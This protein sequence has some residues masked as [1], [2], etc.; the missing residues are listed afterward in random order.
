MMRYNKQPVQDKCLDEVEQ[1]L[2]A[3]EQQIQVVEKQIVKTAKNFL[4]QSKAIG[5]QMTKEEKETLIRTY[6]DSCNKKIENQKN[7]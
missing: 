4:A 3:V 6:G 2:Q 7:S 1:K 5:A